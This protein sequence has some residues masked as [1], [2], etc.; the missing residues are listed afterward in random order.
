MKKIMFDNHFGLENAVLNGTKTMTRRL[1]ATKGTHKLVEK[2]IDECD[3]DGVCNYL[4]NNH[5]RFQIGD[6]VAIAQP[7]ESLVK[8][9][10]HGQEENFA[11]RILEAHGKKKIAEVFGWTNKMYVRSDLMPHQ[12]RITDIW[13]ERL[14]DISDE[15]CMNEGIYIDETRCFDVETFKDGK[16]YCFDVTRK[17]TSTWFFP[18]PKLAFEGLIRKMYGKKV[19]DDNPYVFVY[20][21]ELVK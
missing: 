20:T 10:Y 1:V 2:M 18:T 17:H 12:I 14:Q 8:D 5:S 21:F 11:N 4:I 9:V 6:V 15:D 13:I 7:Y 16:A 19:W 3:H